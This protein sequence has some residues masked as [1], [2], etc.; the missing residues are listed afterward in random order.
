MTSTTKQPCRPPTGGRR[1]SECSLE[2]CHTSVHI[3]IADKFFAVYSY[4]ILRLS[5]SS[6]ASLS[7]LVQASP[8][9]TRSRRAPSNLSRARC[10]TS[11]TAP[12]HCR[13]ATPGPSWPPSNW[14][15]ELTHPS[16]QMENYFER[17]R[18]L[19]FILVLVVRKRREKHANVIYFTL[20]LRK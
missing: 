4:K 7:A 1:S 6:H 17:E 8:P 18:F 15:S 10:T 5:I 11:T 2:P 19:I 16:P 20:W 14:P 12:R 3:H 13:R 9:P